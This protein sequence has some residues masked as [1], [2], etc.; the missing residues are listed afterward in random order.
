MTPS[1]WGIIV[2]KT[3]VSLI[4]SVKIVMRYNLGPD[5][6]IH[7]DLDRQSHCGL[8]PNFSFVDMHTNVY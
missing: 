6:N 8:G 2:N 4:L 5:N 7:F 3:I 1:G